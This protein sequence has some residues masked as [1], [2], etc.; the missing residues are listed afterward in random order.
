MFEVNLFTPEQFGA[1][2]PWLVLNRGPL[3]ALVHPNT[4]DDVRDHSQRA[5]WLGEPLPVNLAPL[6]R[7]VE[8]KRREEEEEKGREKG[9]EKEKGQEREQEQAKV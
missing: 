3:S 7:M 5:T 2:V 6:R 4:G 8:A 9:R 1:F